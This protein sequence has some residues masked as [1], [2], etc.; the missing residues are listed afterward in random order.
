[1]L[2]K[3]ECLLLSHAHEET[4]CLLHIFYINKTAFLNFL[5]HLHLKDQSEK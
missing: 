5:T 1:M 3:K 4:L 2:L